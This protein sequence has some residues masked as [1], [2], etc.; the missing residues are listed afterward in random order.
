[1]TFEEFK[2]KYNNAPYSLEEFANIAS[3]LSDRFDISRRA[4]EFLEAKERFERILNYEGM[5]LG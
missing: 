1:M 3:K 5:E 4:T 2:N